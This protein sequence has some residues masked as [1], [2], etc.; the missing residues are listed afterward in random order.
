MDGE[1]LY[2]KKFGACWGWEISV[3]LTEYHFQVFVSHR[4]LRKNAKTWRDS[5]TIIG[6]QV[7]EQFFDILQR[8]RYEP[9][10][11]KLLKEIKDDV[12]ILYDTK[13]SRIQC[14]DENST[15][16]KNLIPSWYRINHLITGHEVHVDLYV[17]NEAESIVSMLSA[18]ELSIDVYDLLFRWD[19]R[20]YPWIAGVK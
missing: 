4:F 1:V 18:K 3:L 11:D 15:I 17:I 9:S 14:L 2:G 16:F 8:D 5:E 7:F 10:D 13:F 20:D 12:Q 6:R 19:L